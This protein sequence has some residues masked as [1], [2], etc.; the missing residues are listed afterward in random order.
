MSDF[1]RPGET[2]DETVEVLLRALGA[3]AP[4][5]LEHSLRVAHLA[6]VIAERIGVQ[7]TEISLV[8]WGGLLHD[9][10]KIGVPDRLL[11][12]PARLTSEETRVMQ[13]HSVIGHGMIAPI[14]RLRVPAEIVLYHHE[15]FDGSGYPSGL[16]GECI[17]VGARLVAIADV[18]D[19]LSHARPYRTALPVEAALAEI[20]LASGARYDPRL[21]RAF[22]ELAEQGE[23][24]AR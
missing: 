7:T 18:F 13:E 19:A 2:G 24:P 16:K 10:G 5:V 14:R 12:K 11:F 15:R 1:S 21:V 6:V 8:E 3:R 20:R 22:V 17:P 23:L 4:S 9:L